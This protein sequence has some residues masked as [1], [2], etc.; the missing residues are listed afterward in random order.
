M[1]SSLNLPREEVSPRFGRLTA[2]SSFASDNGWRAS[3]Q[4]WPAS[5]TSRDFVETFARAGLAM[6]GTCRLYSCVS[7][8]TAD[9]RLSRVAPIGISWPDL[10][11]WQGSQVTVSMARFAFGGGA[12]QRSHVVLT[13]STSASLRNTGN[14]GW[15]GFR[16]QYHLSGFDESFVPLRFMGC[17][18]DWIYAKGQK[19]PT[20]WQ[21]CRDPSIDCTT[22]GQ[23]DRKNR[24][25]SSTSRSP[26]SVL[27]TNSPT[28]AIP[29]SR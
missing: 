6:P 13:M 3:A 18:P 4:L 1:S 23:V 14:G 29:A 17:T 20:A 28:D 25:R 8:A 5:R 9:F 2:P 19:R 24:N 26:R 16:R 7:P 27:S 11:P 10:P 15:P 21:V 12:E 22:M